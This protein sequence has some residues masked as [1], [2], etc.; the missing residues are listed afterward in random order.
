[1]NL[2]FLLR[3]IIH[4]KSQ[5]VVFILCVALS[6]ISIVAVNSLRRDVNNSIISDA[7]SLH[8][9]DI[10]VHSHYDYSPALKSELKAVQADGSVQSV[11]TWEFYSVARKEDGGDSLLS[12]IKVVESAFPLYG[13]VV[14]QSGRALSRVLLPGRVVV[15]E[16]LLK[17]LGLTL[18]D[19]LLL[20]QAAFEIVDVVASESFRPVEFLNFG[21]RI[22]VS[23]VDL[24]RMDLVNKRSRVNYKMLLK[25]NDDRQVDRVVTRLQKKSTAGQERVT[26]FANT[27][28]RVKRFFDNL[29]FFLSLISVFTLL[30]AGIGMQ[31]SLAALLR[32]KEKTFAM[33]RSLGA[34]GIFLTLHYLVFVLILSCIGWGLGIGAGLLVEKNFTYFFSGLL[35]AQIDL[36]ISVLDVLEGVGLGVL[37]VL[38]FTYLPL[39]GIKMVKP[40]AIFRKETDYALRGR[41][42]WGMF[43]CGLLLLFWL[44]MYQLEDVTIG[45][46]FMAGL[47]FLITLTGLLVSTLLFV[48]ARVR[49]KSLTLRQAVRSLL[50][51]GNATRSIV[52]TLSSSLAVLLTIFLVEYNLYSTYIASYPEDAPS[53]FCLDIQKNQ[54]KGFMDLVG[55]DTELFPVI[56][57][58]LT[59]I[60][61]KNI[62]RRDEIKKRGDSLAREFNLT[63]RETLLEDEVLEEGSTLFP[64]GNSQ[65]G[66]IPVSILDTVADMGN[67]KI[68]D[69]LLFNI[70]GVPME[71]RVSSIR[72]RTKSML[73]PFFYYV[74][75]EK[76]LKAAPHTFFAAMNVDKEMIPQL[77]NRIVNR[78][79]NISTVNVSETAAELGV[80]MLKLT[81]IIV[82]FASF[83]ILAGALILVSSILATRMARVREAVYYKILG[84]GSRFVMQVFF[85]EN[86]L[87]ALLSGGCAILLGQAGSW[88]ICS[89]LLDIDYN[90]HWPGCALLLA[91][92]VFLVV[93]LGVASSFSI[94]RRKPAIF[95][96]EQLS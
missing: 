28:S 37:A 16:T 88:A 4:S 39:S 7:K 69:V 19:S 11:Q 52:V 87:L 60:N 74:F 85:F 42:S 34:S 94:I 84:A 65:Q 6:L 9:G 44:I 53:L 10:I 41:R 27:G 77:E 49:V 59:S 31:S 2:R 32:R 22:F 47:L 14:L 43:G 8:G 5:A 80:I 46:Y 96:R 33:T 78:F 73:Y 50:Q 68:G 56:R 25:L 70:Q 40:S 83:S 35:P 55:T 23:A 91:G 29:L 1:M 81:K 61:G 89:L 12:N 17:R 15:A 51:P 71:A 82:F 62:S 64:E 67:M 21:P 54:Q 95:L 93:C 38:F 3:E 66:I 26:T 79:P 30:L 92:T 86:L 58:R 90:P 45:L 24:E 72:S 18:G 76:H 20:G 63:Y 13:E 75:Q 48:L 36:G 57:A